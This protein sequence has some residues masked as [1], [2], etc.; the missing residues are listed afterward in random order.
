MTKGAVF[1]TTNKYGIT[2]LELI[3]EDGVYSRKY[4]CTKCGA[5]FF[6][7]RSPGAARHPKCPVLVGRRHRKKDDVERVEIDEIDD[8]VARLRKSGEVRREIEAEWAS[9]RAL[10]PKER[11]T[12]W[13]VL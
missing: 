7:S 6:A 9:G 2:Y 11:R 13:S 3:C 12:G 10:D 1:G 5:V 4:L 8:F